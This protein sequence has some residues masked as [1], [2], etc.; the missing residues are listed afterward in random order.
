VAAISAAVSRTWTAS[1]R[2]RSAADSRCFI[3]RPPSGSGCPG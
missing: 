3:V 1:V 2:V